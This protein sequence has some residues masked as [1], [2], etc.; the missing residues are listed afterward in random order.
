M[1]RIGR[2]LVAVLVAVLVAG[3]GGGDGDPPKPRA[4]SGV[5]AASGAASSPGA[6]RQAVV[7]RVRLYHETVDA[8]A[9][10]EKVDMTKLRAV[11]VAAWAQLLGKNLQETKDLGYVVAGEVKRTVK[12]VRVTGETAEYVQCIDQRGVS[13]VKNGKPEPKGPVQTDPPTLATFTMVKESE[14]WKVRSGTT[15]GTC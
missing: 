6:E 10:G 7:A 1:V 13:M 4:S 2:R 14:V 8:I 5:S 11:A 15:T 9:A 3:C 12:S